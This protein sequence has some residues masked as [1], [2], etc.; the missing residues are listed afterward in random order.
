MQ[1]DVSSNDEPMRLSAEAAEMMAFEQ[2]G[3]VATL[4][5]SR[6]EVL[7]RF[8]ADMHREFA[9]H[10]FPV[11][12]AVQ[13]DVIGLGATVVLG[14]DAVVACKGARIADP[15][16]KVGLVGDD[17]GC[18]VGP[19]AAGMLRARP[20]LRT[21]PIKAED[22]WLWGLVTDLGEESDVELAARDVHRPMRRNR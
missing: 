3:H 12:A 9:R 21:D 15:H 1:S 18:V 19:Q 14:C 22:A 4:R 8:D 16:V 17:G 2:D 11:I 6:P 7:D 5:L 10:H 13:G 20:H